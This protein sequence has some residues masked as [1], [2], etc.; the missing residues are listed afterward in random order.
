MILAELQ[1]PSFIKQFAFLEY[2]L[3]RGV[4]YLFIGSLTFAV[5]GING[6]VSI[7]LMVFG[8]IVML[9]GIA[10]IIFQFI[11]QKFQPNDVKQIDSPNVLYQPMN[12]PAP[13][14]VDYSDFD[15]NTYATGGI[16]LGKPNPNYGENSVVIPVI[17]S[18]CENV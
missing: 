2:H 17:P 1:I 6:V 18:N 13:K 16:E 7:I 11:G 12:M 15:P 10:Q 4:F 8:I 3:G 9:C 5:F 14:Q